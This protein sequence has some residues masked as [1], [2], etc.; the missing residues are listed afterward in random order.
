MFADMPEDVR[1]RMAYLEEIDARDRDD[2]TPRLERLRQ[3]PPETGQFIA[4]LSLTAPAGRHIEIG[5]SAG[6]STLWLALACRR[7][8][9]RITTYEILP[10]KVRLAKETF[11]RTGLSDVIE[12]VEGDARD[13]IHGVSGIS[14]CFLDAEKEVYKDCYDLVVPR[15]VSGGL[16]VADNA[17]NHRD[18]LQA[19]IEEALADPRVDAMVVPVGK[20]ELVCRKR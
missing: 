13:H 10:E 18:A 14:F 6:Y 8:G 7:L 1:R 19:M 17:I 2:G 15:M 5:T 12:L 20:G 4:L 3:V 16:L 9:R 11:E